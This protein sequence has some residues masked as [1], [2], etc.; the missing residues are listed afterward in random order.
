M[1]ECEKLLGDDYKVIYI[2]GH[3]ATHL[4][5]YYL[6]HNA[7]INMSP[8]IVLYR[9]GIEVARSDKT[10]SPEKLSNWIRDQLK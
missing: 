2:L 4:G 9:N 5:V 10:Y 8:C 7:T 3:I 1:F 6:I